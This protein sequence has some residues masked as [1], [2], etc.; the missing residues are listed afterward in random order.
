MFVRV[1]GTLLS[2]PVLVNGI[3][4]VVIYDDDRN[5]VMLI[6]ELADNTLLVRKPNDKGFSAALREIGAHEGELTVRQIQ[7]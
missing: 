7:G 5:A 2:K 6:Q 3:R 1:Q 4:S